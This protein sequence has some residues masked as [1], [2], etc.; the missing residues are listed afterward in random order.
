MRSL[1]FSI[2]RSSSNSSSE[3][4]SSSEDALSSS[5]VSFF[6]VREEAGASAFAFSLRFLADS[7][8]FSFSKPVAIMVISWNLPCSGQMQHPRSQLHPRVLHLQSWYMPVSISSML[9]S[10]EAVIL[11]KIPLAPLM[12]VSSSGLEMAAFAASSAFSLPEAVPTP[13]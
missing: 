9:M 12:E 7:A 3:I 4:S 11:P 2:P 1:F 5:P 8:S 10:G 6:S 13:I